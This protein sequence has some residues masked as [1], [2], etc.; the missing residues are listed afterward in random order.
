MHAESESVQPQPI[1]QA[2]GSSRRSTTSPRMRGR[3]L[4]EVPA[5]KRSATRAGAKRILAKVS[6]GTTL[7]PREE[8]YKPVEI[9]EQS[10]VPYRPI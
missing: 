3:N 7:L 2:R 9:D 5:A 6:A 10:K 1:R 8:A 4:L